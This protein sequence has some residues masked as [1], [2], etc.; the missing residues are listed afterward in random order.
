MAIQAVGPHNALCVC[1]WR[2]SLA[3]T[4]RFP[5]VQYIGLSPRNRPD[6]HPFASPKQPSASL[7]VHARRKPCAPRARRRPGTF[8]RTNQF[9]YDA[10]P[11]RPDPV[12]AQKLQEVLGG[13]WGEMSVMMTYLFQGWNCRAPAKYRDMI[14]DIATEE[15]AHVGQTV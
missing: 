12:Y 13:Q 6:H 4:I 11:E 5:I 1:F 7:G 14:L 10:K 8:F 9:Q 2:P 15:I 3:P